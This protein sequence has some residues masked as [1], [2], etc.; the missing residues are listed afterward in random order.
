MKII[1]K[2]KAINDDW[3]FTHPP[4]ILRL[5]EIYIRGDILVLL[6]FLT[7]ILLVGFFSVRFMLVIYAVFFT[8]RHFGE[9]TYW[10]L[11]Q[12]S[13]KS[14]RPDDLGFKNLSNE[15]IYVIYQLKAVVKITIGISV[16]IFLLFFS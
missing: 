14:Y 6:P 13:D 9:M 7:L 1:K 11:K 2:L 8:V 10:L 4:S 15:A 12:F 16:I 3:F 5:L